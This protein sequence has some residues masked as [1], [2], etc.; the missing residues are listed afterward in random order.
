MMDDSFTL[1]LHRYALED[2]MGGYKIQTHPTGPD[3]WSRHWSHPGENLTH[4]Y[5]H[6]LEL[7]QKWQRKDECHGSRIELVTE[8]ER[9]VIMEYPPT[10]P[11]TRY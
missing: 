5:K 10:G 3:R 7:A 1:E 2:G 8:G 6:V 11:Y 9:M 4:T